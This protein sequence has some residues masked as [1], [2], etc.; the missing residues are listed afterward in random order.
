[1]T[2]SRAGAARPARR[3]PA[4][5]SRI[6]A[7]S[8]SATAMFTIVSLL[9]VR[10]EQAQV[11]T[12]PTPSATDVAAA[13]LPPRQVTI[14]VTDPPPD[15]ASGAPP[16]VDPAAGEVVDAGAVPVAADS[17]GSSYVGG[18]DPGVGGTVTTSDPVA[19]APVAAP[20]APAATPAPA[21][22]PAPS[23]ST[24]TGGS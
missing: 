6:A 12:A 16:A 9:A 3:R 20:A 19:T 15:A 22:A 8:L 10:A 5:L 17:P 18:S 24:G 14:Y 13:A 7:A 21:P 2:E 4:A 11:V 23:P 1:M